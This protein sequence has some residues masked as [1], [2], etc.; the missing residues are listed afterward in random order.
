MLAQTKNTQDSWTHPDSVAGPLG[1]NPDTFWRRAP[2]GSSLETFLT[3]EQ[4][5]KGVITCLC[6]T[7]LHTR[8]L[9]HHLRDHHFDL[10][11]GWGVRQPYAAF[12][13][14]NCICGHFAH[15]D[16]NA[17][18]WAY[19]MH[20]S[21]RFLLQLAKPGFL[22]TQGSHIT[23]FWTLL[24]CNLKVFLGIPAYLVYDIDK[25]MSYMIRIYCKFTNQT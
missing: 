20:L 1:W 2:D 16:E 24:T 12:P 14:R 5:P 7:G 17:Y 6:C 4:H 8:R 15:F 22:H 23:R 11:K 21:P 3:R 9:T 19:A 18:T 13:A 10:R 25:I